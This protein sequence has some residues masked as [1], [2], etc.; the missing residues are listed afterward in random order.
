MLA[1]DNID[2]PRKEMPDQLLGSGVNF[3]GQ[4][5]NPYP[6]SAQAGQ[7]FRY[8]IIWYRAVMDMCR[9]LLLEIRQR[10]INFRLLCSGR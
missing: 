3:I 2:F 10:S 9:I 6:A 1:K 4:Y 5:A 8:A 7:Q